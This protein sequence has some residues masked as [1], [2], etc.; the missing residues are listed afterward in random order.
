[1]SEP[2][3]PDNPPSGCTVYTAEVIETWRRKKANGPV[4]RVIPFSDEALAQAF[5]E[6]HADDLRYCEAFGHWFEWD[7]RRWTMDRMRRVFALA[8]GVCR[9]Q[10]N[11]AAT[12]IDNPRTAAKLAHKVASAAS[13]AAVVNLARCDP[14][15]ATAQGDWDADPWLLNTPGGMVDLKTGQLRPHDRNILCSKITAVTPTPGPLA[16]AACPLWLGFLDQATAGNAGLQRY[17]QR[18]VGYALTG[19]ISEHSMFFLHGPGGNGKGVFLNTMTGIL[20]DYA[21]VAPM[22]TFTASAND[23][24][25]TDLTVLHGDH[26]IGFWFSASCRSRDPDGLRASEFQHPVQGGSSDGDLGRLVLISAR[27][28]GITD[29]AFVTTDRRLDS[30]PKIIAAGLLPAHPAVPS[31]G[32]EV[33][34]TLC[35]SDLS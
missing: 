26:G 5:A 24:H 28:K 6:R 8:R 2:F 33:E 18:V 22:E 20:A 16:A 15:L 13:I 3:D 31:D 27:S 14:H 11:L 10:S 21:L 7:G 34:V 23:R 32:L 17:L 4:E 1:M 19:D 29:H 9:E 12:S 30:G 25:P 35:G